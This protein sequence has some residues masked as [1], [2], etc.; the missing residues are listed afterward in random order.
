LMTFSSSDVAACCSRASF[1]SRASASALSFGVVPDRRA[2][3]ALLALLLAGPGRG[4]FTCR[5]LPP[6]RRMAPAGVH[7]T[8]QAY[9]KPEGF[10]NGRVEKP[11]EVVLASRARIF[12]AQ[13]EALD[14]ARRRE[15]QGFTQLDPARKFP[16]AGLVLDVVLERL[17]QVVVGLEAVAQHDEGL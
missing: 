6:R 12:L 13:L 3:A 10:A 4:F 15:R 1:S 5:L 16:R 8:V 2:L 7:D 17:E 11:V 9:E 14:L